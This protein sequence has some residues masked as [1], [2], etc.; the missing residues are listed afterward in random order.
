MEDGPL[1]NDVAIN[2]ITKIALA[3]GVRR[4]WVAKDGLASTPA[5]SALIREGGPQWK[6]GL[7]LLF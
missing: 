1:H 6:K 5:V 4:V 7:A 3:N 2:I